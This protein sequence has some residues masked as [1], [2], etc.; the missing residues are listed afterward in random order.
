[1]FILFYFAIVAT[2]LAFSQIF[3]VRPVLRRK[4]EGMQVFNIA[5]LAHSQQRA[6][7]RAAEAGGFADALG[8]DVGAGF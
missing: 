4:A 5:A 7:D 2:G 6:H 3:I 8:V 1:M